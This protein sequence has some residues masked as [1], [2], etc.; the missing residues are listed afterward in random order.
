[1]AHRLSEL[2]A[3]IGAEL[4]GDGSRT[5]RA[6][7]ALAAAGEEDLSFATGPALRQAARA[8]R[9][10]AL[11]VPAEL[12][13]LDDRPLL[14][15]ADPKLALARLLAHLHP[16]AAP[17]AGVH[18]TAV[19]GEGCRI[20]PSA[21]IAPYAV[22]GDGSRIAAGA[23]VGA[24]AVVG[25]GCR[26][27][28]GAVLHPHVVLYDRTVVG[29]RSIVHAGTVLG[30][31]G[32]GYA[33][34]GAAHVKLPHVGRVVIGAEV[35]IGALSAV[36]RALTEETRVGDGT[37]IDNLVQVGHNVTIGKGCVLCG[38]VGLAGTAS[39]GD[40]VVMAGQS[41]AGDHVEI[42]DG[43]RVAARSAVLQSVAAGREVG[44]VPAI[45]LSAWR[46]QVA[47]LGRLAEIARRLRAVEKK[48]AALTGEE[49]RP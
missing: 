27:E 7:R 9:A 21:A 44:G 25:R 37:K 4:R 11:L 13:D 24:H 41:G 28:A 31:D 32:F 39:L 12:A 6:V 14:V 15:V 30:A 22:I 10:G 34:D 46:R 8:S 47:A 43:T 16:P 18:P 20:D 3:L 33:Q 40:G 45:E 1:M 35:E 36:D 48:L 19:I 42:G 23:V 2:A 29:E 38:Q 26:L 17:A 49:E 5:V